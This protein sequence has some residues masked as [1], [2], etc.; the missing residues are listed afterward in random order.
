[1][2]GLKTVTARNDGNTNLESKYHNNFQSEATWSSPEKLFLFFDYLT[3]SSPEKLF[4]FFDYLTCSPASTN[5]ID[6][7]FL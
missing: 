7:D 3:C 2:L 4:L 6:C 5:F 1:M